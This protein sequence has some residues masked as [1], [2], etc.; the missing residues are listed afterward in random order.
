M[1]EFAIVLPVLYYPS[2]STGL[3]GQPFRACEV[4]TVQLPFPLSGSIKIVQSA[5]MRA[6]MRVEVAA[7]PPPLPTTNTGWATNAPPA[8]TCPTT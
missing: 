3:V 5:E 1:V 2:G 6:E 4:S 7:T 8:N